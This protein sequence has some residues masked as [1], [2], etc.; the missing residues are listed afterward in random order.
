MYVLTIADSAIP[1]WSQHEQRHDGQEQL[2]HLD[3]ISKQ[4]D[5]GEISGRFLL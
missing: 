1:A 5:T 3:E 2:R 4:A